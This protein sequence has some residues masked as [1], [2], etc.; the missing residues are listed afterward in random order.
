MTTFERMMTGVDH[1]VVSSPW[2]SI[3]AEIDVA[4][5]STVDTHE[6]RRMIVVVLTFWRATCSLDARRLPHSM[7]EGSGARDT[8]SLCVVRK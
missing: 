2:L 8:S 5:M 6:M 3:V 7:S 4:V 1:R